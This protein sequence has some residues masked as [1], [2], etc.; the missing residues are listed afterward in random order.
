MATTTEPQ[1]QSR[2]R[3]RTAA[4]TARP[5]ILVVD[6]DADLRDLLVLALGQDGWQIDQAK[7]AH[8]A[9][10][11]LRRGGFSLVITDYDLPGRTGGQMLAEA[12]KERLLRDCAVL[13][14]TGHPDP[15]DVGEAPVIAKPFDLDVLRRQVRHILER[16]KAKAP[17]PAAATQ[18]QPAGVELVL[19][20]ARSS[21]A[22]R[23]AHRN[24]RRILDGLPA[25]MARLTIR[26]VAEH[27]REA[28]R[29]RILF[30]PTLVVRCAA[31]IWVVGNLRNPAALVGILDLCGDGKAP[32]A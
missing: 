29:D 19:Y 12:A 32:G 2:V 15:G 24:L 25:G 18:A 4:P 22:S 31:P 27:P 30:A 9:L 10:A 16:T 1:K 21:T 13:V 20:V 23:L 3:A 26:D 14:V 5:R 17:V 28:E 6:D 11:L 7:D 8:E